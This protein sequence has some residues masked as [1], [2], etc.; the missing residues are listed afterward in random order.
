MVIYRWWLMTNKSQKETLKFRE[1]PWKSMKITMFDAEIPVKS[2]KFPGN[3]K[4]DRVPRKS[5][6][7]TISS[8]QSHLNR[9]KNALEFHENPPFFHDVFHPTWAPPVGNSTSLALSGHMHGG[10]S[11][12]LAGHGIGR[13]QGHGRQGRAL[14]RY[15][16]SIWCPFGTSIINHH[17]YK[18]VPHS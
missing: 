12:L 5:Q 2:H 7:I 10:P 1:K 3:K 18:V 15:G 13:R 17:Y 14:G 16:W 6:N 8:V 11:Q 9:N 4:N